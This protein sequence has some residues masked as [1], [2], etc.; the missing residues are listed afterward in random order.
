M[1]FQNKDLKMPKCYTFS[2]RGDQQMLSGKR[3]YKINLHG[4]IG[5][6]QMSKG[7]GY[8]KV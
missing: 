4:I 6:N 8:S 3:I 5:L 2:M 1:Y 7:I